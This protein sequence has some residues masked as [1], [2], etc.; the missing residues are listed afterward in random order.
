[1]TVKVSIPFVSCVHFLRKHVLTNAF[2]SRLVL[3]PTAARIRASSEIILACGTISTPPLLQRSGL[4]PRDVLEPLG[5]P[6]IEDLPGVGRGLMDHVALPVVWRVRKDI[7]T[8][9]DLRTDPEKL[10][11]ALMQYQKDRT[12]SPA[13]LVPG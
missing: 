2:S 1:M 11:A 6:V 7:P 5:I 8:A 4:G 13:A 9:D 3:S 12:V 10:Q